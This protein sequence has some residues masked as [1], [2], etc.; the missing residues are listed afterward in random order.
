MPW[1]MPAAVIGSGLLQGESAKSAAQQ[2]AQSNLE[3]ARIAAE[4]AKFRPVGLTTRYGTSQFRMT[5]EGYLESAGYTLSPE[6]QAYQQQISGLLGQQLQQGL[7]AQQQY[8]PLQRAAGGLFN[9]GAGY[10]A[11]TPEQAAQKYMESQQALLAPARERESA[12]LD[13]KST[14]LNSSH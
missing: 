6:Y 4:Q 5:P 10:L 14:R 9:L 11:Q 13:R 3:A 7:G 1:M 2:A 8:E 12:L